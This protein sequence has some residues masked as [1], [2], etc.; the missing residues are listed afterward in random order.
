LIDF[1]GKV[2]GHNADRNTWL[3]QNL[4]QLH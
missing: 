3:P 2:G 4:I 1:I